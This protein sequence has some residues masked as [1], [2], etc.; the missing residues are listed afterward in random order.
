MKARTRLLAVLLFA[1]TAPLLAQTAAPTLKLPAYKK[2]KL[3][4]GLTVFLMEKH[5]V[6]MVSFS[7]VV[8]A[9][10]VAD[11]AGKEG[12]ASLTA[13]LLRKGT[14]TRTAD[15]VSE[16]LDFLGA[17]F[18]G[19]VSQDHTS[20]QAEFMKK[21]VPEG[22]DILADLLLNPTFPEAEV[23]KLIKQNLDGL[24]AARDRAAGVLPQYYSHYLF[25][26]HPYGRP[27]DGDENSLKAITRDDIVNFHKTYCTP[28]N[29]ILAVVGD[30]DTA[31]MEK[32]VEQKLGAWTGKTPAPPALP[33]PVAYKGKKLL[34]VDKPDSTQTYFN[35]G[36]VGIARDNPD[37]V[38]IEVVNTLFGGRFTSMINSELRI[39]SGLTY[40][41]NSGFGRYKVPGPFTISSYTANKNTEKALDLTLD[42]VKRLQEKGITEEELQSAKNYIKGQYPPRIETSD[43]LANLL[44][45]LEFY[46]LD[47]KE[48]NNYYANIDSMDLAA[49]KRVIQQYFPADNLVFV[50]IGK[51]SEIEPVV[52]KYAAQ[53]DKKSITEP[54]F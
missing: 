8:R 24:K 44:T 13:D 2:L 50:L 25:G 7:F 26:T 11:P 15:Q 31:E 9:G 49:A 19:G 23:T 4:N 33:Q 53:M 12:T 48:I 38:Y 21:D 42:V 30:F 20:G 32:L 41:A 18:G 40:G 10:A 51:A 27:V 14:P 5:Q 45:S 47:E 34:L 17:R 16:Q 54:G 39:K 35:I 52:K 46:G 3:K 1:L 37:R 36:N 22:M 43:A 29:A 6:P 28:G